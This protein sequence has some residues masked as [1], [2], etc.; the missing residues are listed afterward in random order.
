M[1]LL[2]V[3]RHNPGRFNFG[4]N[5]IRAFVRELS[6]ESSAE[7]FFDTE[8]ERVAAGIFWLG[9]TLRPE[10]FQRFEGGMEEKASELDLEA[11]G[12]GMYE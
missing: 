10:R 4:Q 6:S 9:T 5:F 11:F 7:I 8:G 2:Q 1:C 3:V 12:C